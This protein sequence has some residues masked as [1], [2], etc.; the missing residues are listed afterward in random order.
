MVLM[1]F[2]HLVDIEKYM[3]YIFNETK[4]NSGM[5]S[6]E[7]NNNALGRMMCL[8]ACIEAKIFF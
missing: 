3:K 8:S 6:S 4:V 2:K 7:R 5:K 1:K